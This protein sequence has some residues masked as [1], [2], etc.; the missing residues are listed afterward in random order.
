MLKSLRVATDSPAPRLGRRLLPFVLLAFVAL[1]Y[2]LVAF[3]LS[4]AHARPM[5]EPFLRISDSDYFF[6]ATFFYAPVIAAAWLLA[7]G[8]IYVMAWLGN[9]RPD[10][11]RV[12][13]SIAAATGVGTL[14]TLIP[15]LLTSPLRLAGVIGEEAWEQSIATQGVWFYFTWATLTVYLLVFA[16]AYPVA[17]HRA[18]GIAWKAA[19]PIGLAG[20]ALFQ[21][22]EL[23][24][25]R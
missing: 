8:A 23:V 24:F 1:G 25:I 20:F 17:V 13:T 7:S 11:D 19:V 2:S 3:E 10:F 22:F 12:L 16:V 6:W 21:G 9:A 5:P 4:A 18:T 15:D 14:G